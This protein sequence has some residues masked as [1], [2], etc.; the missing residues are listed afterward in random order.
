MTDLAVPP[1]SEWESAGMAAGSS[2]LLDRGSCP[3]QVQPDDITVWATQDAYRDHVFAVSPPAPTVEVSSRLRRRPWLAAV[4]TQINELL[5]LENGWNGHGERRIDAEN[6]VRVVG[7][8][9]EADFDGEAPD[10]VPLHDGSVQAEW[11]AA[12]QSLEIELPIG[13]PASAWWTDGSDEQEW[14]L[15]SRRDLES[16]RRRLAFVTP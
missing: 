8:L 7:V 1:R 3:A 11:H 16:L 5:Q 12:P 15:T 2:T 4:L 10:V 13:G 6:A 14:T 9:D